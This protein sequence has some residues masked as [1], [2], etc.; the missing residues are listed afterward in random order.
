MEQHCGT[1]LPNTG[2]YFTP[3]ASNQLPHACTMRTPSLRPE[4][5]LSQAGE[6]GPVVGQTP[7]LRR[8]L[9]QARLQFVLRK[10]RPDCFILPYTNSATGRFDLSNRPLYAAPA[11]VH[12]PEHGRAK[13]DRT[14]FLRSRPEGLESSVTYT[15]NLLRHCI[16]SSGYRQR[17]PIP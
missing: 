4:H 16:M 11:A 5:R 2:A 6:A 10:T 8:W 1:V 14:S 9:E 17:L 13:R 12:S 3:V 7:K 15:A